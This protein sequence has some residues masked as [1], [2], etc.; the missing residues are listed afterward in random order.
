MCFGRSLD[1]YHLVSYEPALPQVTL[2]LAGLVHL[3][4]GDID[5]SL[6]FCSYCE[7][8]RYQLGYLL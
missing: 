3:G 8:Y 5:E 1:A 4:S 7:S 6:S 2:R